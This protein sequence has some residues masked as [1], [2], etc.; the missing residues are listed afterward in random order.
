MYLYKTEI[1]FLPGKGFPNHDLTITFDNSVVAPTQTA[2]N[3]GVT[4]N[5][6]LSLT[7]NIADGVYGL[8]APSL[9]GTASHSTNHC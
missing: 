8:A 6:Q 1:L 5:N 2:R 4:L 9:R 7:A 3:L